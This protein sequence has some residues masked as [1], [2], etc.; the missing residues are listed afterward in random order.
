MR[1]EI[2]TAKLHKNKLKKKDSGYLFFKDNIRLTS[3][4]NS[5]RK[6]HN[7]LIYCYF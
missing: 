7:R 4:L 6:T 3:L 2:E 5:G 1:T